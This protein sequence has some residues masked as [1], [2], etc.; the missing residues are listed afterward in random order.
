MTV[1]A[2]SGGTE[3]DNVVFTLSASP[4]PSVY[5]D[6]LVKV[7]ASGDFGV[8]EGH[9]VVTIYSGGSRKLTLYTDGDFVD[10]PDGSVTAT[11][12]AWKGFPTS[13]FYDYTVGTP[14]SMSAAVTDDDN[15]PRPTPVVS[16]AA[17]AASVVEGG[18]AS[19]T[20]T[21]DPKPTAPLAVTV[22]VAPQGD[23]GVTAGPRTAI[24]PVSG[25]VAFAVP[26]SG[27]S[28]D[29]PDGSVTATLVD[30]ADYDLG[31]AK[32]ATV[33]VADDDPPA[34]QQV[35]PP[36]VSVSA[37]SGGTEGGDVVFTLGAV[38][39]P[40][41]DLD[42]SVEVSVS[43]DFG[44]AA[45]SRTVTVD[46]TGSGTLTLATDDDSVDEADG[47]VTLTVVAGNGYTVGALSSLSAAVT[48]DDDP[49]AQ[50]A[51]EQQ[52][53]PQVKYADLISD[54][55]GYI[56]ET[57]RP[58]AAHFE[59]WK[60]VLVAFAVDV[61]GFSGTAMT[62]A[63]A[64]GYADRGWARWDPV[65]EALAWLEA[66][67]DD[68][69][70]QQQ[71]E[72]QPPTP[73]PVVSISRDGSG[74][75]T[76]G[77]SATFT[78]SA[79]PAPSAPIT[80]NVS[81]G[82]NSF[83]ASG[84][85]AVTVSGASASYTVTT[86]D[87]QTDE[88]SG[89]VTVTLASGSG[90]SL[91][92]PASAS[93]PVADDDSPLP[94]PTSVVSI[95]GASSVVEGGAATFT[96]SASPP[97]AS[98]LDVEVSVSAQGDYGAQT[99]SRTVTV[100]ATGSVSFT[101]ATSGDSTDE[102]DGSVTATL[103]DGADY[104]LAAQNAATV[105]VAD[106]D[107]PPPPPTPV[108]SIAADAASVVEGSSASFTVSPSPPPAAPLDVEVSVAA[109]GDYGAQTGSRTVTVPAT[110]SVTFTVPTAGDSAD[111]PDGSVTA[112]LVDGADYDL[113]ASVTATVAVADDDDPPPPPA[114]VVSI[115]AD[116]ASVVEGSSASFTVSPSPP[117]AA[118]LD[119]EVSVAAQGD[120]GAQTGSRTVT[121]PATGSV[122]F[123]VP[124]A[125]DSA[126]EPDGSVTATLVDG[127]DY[128]LGSQNAA[129]VAVTDDDNPPT[130]PP[131]AG[132]SGTLTVSVSHDGTRT[133]RGEMVVF[134]IEASEVAQQD[135]TI[136]FWLRGDRGLVGGLDYCLVGPGA[137][138]PEPGFRCS[139]LDVAPDHDHDTGQAV[140]AEG[141][142]SAQVRVWISANAWI[143]DR[144]LLFITL[145]E[146]DGAKAITAP[147]THARVV[148]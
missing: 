31:T 73:E 57:W 14:S 12:L 145:T 91:G 76:E 74:L 116:A 143:F 147:N 40:D 71:E 68:I 43:G 97:P 54:V 144:A 30:G 35:D 125:G 3:G 9:Y 66:Q 106:D 88:P 93:F 59:R 70:P 22:S 85:S 84:A 126:D 45:G 133:G 16:I 8:A 37:A 15:P 102:P 25:S 58:N 28:T 117:P 129:T 110:G 95:T 87:D 61:P 132:N 94:P 107:V 127:A 139:D 67:P 29:E 146:L 138:D 121:V 75:V 72:Q 89:T 7:S 135:V 47:S 92:S 60:R 42:V 111:E 124:T 10:E 63:E 123:T 55:R 69:E 38:P 65:S 130:P 62:A 11:V 17:D 148:E 24:V 23:Y 33:A 18:S 78:V 5:L 52:V 122:T 140:I 26:T 118:P 4:S 32:S 120:Y 50:Q 90:Y 134:D 27:D 77:G 6:V 1:S 105:A 79:S 49:P 142:H 39:P 137:A 104:D 48:D 99:G 82:A 51:E 81:V 108:V 115:A 112:T 56:D 96:L 101:V 44:I 80:V 86:V 46:S 83:G 109:Q 114:P 21:A 103:V 119:V 100:P 141:D 20:L 19:F 98:P 113:R 36:E 2:A 53:D 64:Q 34:Q 136:G 13:R 128:D 41:A 131:P